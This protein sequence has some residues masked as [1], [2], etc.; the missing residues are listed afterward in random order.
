MSKVRTRRM[1]K[2][3]ITRERYNELVWF[4]RQYEHLK[5][6]EWA[7][8]IGDVDRVEGGNG[9]WHG[10]SDPTG[11]GGVRLASSPYTWKINA[12]EQS[13]IE[14]DPSLNA[15]ILANVTGRMRYEEMAAPCGRNQFFAARKRFFEAL[16]LRVP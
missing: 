5:R 7:Y 2:S 12:I 14:A 13:A 6:Q 4:A 15:Y 9:H 16:N 11:N 1:E 10:V 3:G 8:R